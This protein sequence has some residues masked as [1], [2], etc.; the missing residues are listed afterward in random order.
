MSRHELIGEWVERRQQAKTTAAARKA[1]LVLLARRMGEISEL[2][3]IGIGTK[4]DAWLES[5]TI[6]SGDE[7]LILLKELRRAE[8]DAAE[9]GRQLSSLGVS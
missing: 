8:A 2:L 4:A 5:H 1:E 3:E 9:A 7:I 6:P